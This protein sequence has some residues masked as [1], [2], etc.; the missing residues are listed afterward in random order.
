MQDPDD[1]VERLPVDRVARVRRLEHG[2]Q[3][4]LGRHLD[5][6]PDDVGSRHHHVR[7]LLVGEVED[8]VEHLALVLLDLA[9]LRRHLEQHLQ[10]RLRVRRAFDLARVDADRALRDLARALQEP[11]QRLEDEEEGPHGNR[12]AERDPLRVAEGEPLRHELADDDVHERDDQE[13]EQHR[14]ERAEPDPEQIRQDLLADRADRE[15]RERDAEL[16]RGDEVRRIA[17]D[18]HHRARR[19]APLVD[20]LLQ[21]GAAHGDERVLGRDEEPVQQDQKGNGEELERD[22]HAPVSGASVLEGSSSTTA[23][24]YRRR[25]RR[26]HRPP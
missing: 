15:R 4:L 22:R 1:L 6:D 23:R 17:R 24:Q 13:R 21:P 16:H 25:R 26:S 12:D 19:P 2:A 10:L 11:D 18:L 3:R 5:R 14:E 20:E 7:R 9:V 8:L